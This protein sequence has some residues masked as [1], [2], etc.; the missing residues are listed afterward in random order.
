M[1]HIWTLEPQIRADQQFFL[2][3]FG[4]N[5]KCTKILNEIAALN[6]ISYL[7]LCSV[8]RFILDRTEYTVGNH[9][10]II[11]ATTVRR[12]TSFEGNPSQLKKAL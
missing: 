3:D 9:G 10:H 8:K 5:S 11:N 7:I 4:W 6:N 2:Y 1:G 12:R